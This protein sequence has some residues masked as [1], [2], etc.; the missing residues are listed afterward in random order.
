MGHYH[1]HQWLAR[2]LWLRKQRAKR[3]WIEKRP[4][5]DRCDFQRLPCL[6]AAIDLIELQINFLTFFR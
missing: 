2:W 3:W 1:G 6:G 5:R 4:W